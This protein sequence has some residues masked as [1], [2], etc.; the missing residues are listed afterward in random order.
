MSVTAPEDREGQEEQGEG[1]GSGIV[2]GGVTVGDLCFI[3]F[4]SLFP[5][6]LYFTSQGQ[7]GSLSRWW[8]PGTC[9]GWVLLGLAS[10]AGEKS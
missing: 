5:P 1:S 3:L 4:M 9:T 10:R 6:S 7:G 2:L 8:R